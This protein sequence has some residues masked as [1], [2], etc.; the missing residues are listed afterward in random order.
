MART[1]RQY[2]LTVDPNDGGFPIQITMP[3][4][5]EFEVVR[6]A[7][8]SANNS[9]IKIYNLDQNKR[10]RLRRDYV[11]FGTGQQLR[12]VTLKAGYDGNL[13]TIY[14][15]NVTTAQSV[16]NGLNFITTIDSTDIGFALAYDYYSHDPYGPC[17]PY[18]QIYEDIVKFL[19]PAGITLGVIIDDGKKLETEKTIYGQPI[20]LLR[21]LSGGNFYVDNGVANII[22]MNQSITSSS[23]RISS[24][25]GLIGTPVLQVQFVQ[26]EMVFDPSFQLSQHITLDSSTFSNSYNSS[27]SAFYVVNQIKHKGLFSP[28]VNGEATTTLALMGNARM[29]EIGIF[30]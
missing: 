21:E 8:S 30:K 3:I 20:E 12:T 7:W 26:V 14:R 17:T 23:T 16:R 11:D 19:A 29:G 22:P 28:T 9:I 24:D 25:S 6:N 10:N 13:K 1:Y 5:I 4:T 27:T 18:K 15:G 2:E